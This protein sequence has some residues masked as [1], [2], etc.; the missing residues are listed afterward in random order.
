MTALEF[1]EFL[2]HDLPRIKYLMQDHNVAYAAG[3]LLAIHGPS[4]A[5]LAMARWNRAKVKV[6]TPDVTD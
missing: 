1:Q 2:S 4:L 6:V 3:D 5:K